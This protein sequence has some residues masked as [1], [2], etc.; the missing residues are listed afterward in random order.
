MN[1]NPK[2]DIKSLSSFRINPNNIIKQVK[3][4]HRPVIITDRGNPQAVL[5]DLEEYEN[6]R[7]QMELMQA[8]LEGERD[9]EQKKLKSLTAVFKQSRRW[10]KNV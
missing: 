1:I 3:K 10:L 4:N 2:E 6:Q 7:D 9:V 8:I 5:V